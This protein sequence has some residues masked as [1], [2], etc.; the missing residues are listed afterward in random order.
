MARF[1]SS[2]YTTTTD[3]YDLSEDGRTV[4]YKRVCLLC[5]GDCHGQGVTVDWPKVRAEMIE[6]L[7]LADIDGR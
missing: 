7:E 1:Y 5:V 6:E 4:A 2:E 3:Q